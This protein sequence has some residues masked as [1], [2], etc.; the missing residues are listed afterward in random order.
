MKTV[1][2][3]FREIDINSLKRDPDCF[4]RQ[5]SVRKYKVTIEEI[6]DS[7]EEIWARL[8]ELWNKSDNFHNIQPIKEMA[9]KIGYEIV[10]E[11][12]KYRKKL[13]SK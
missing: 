11:F 8:Q 13:P 2:E 12:W 9:K 4:N 7:V 1:F 3:T 5:V 6:E 10:W